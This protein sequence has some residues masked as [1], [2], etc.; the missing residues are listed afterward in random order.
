[1]SV[2]G[3]SQDPPRSTTPSSVT[4]SSSRTKSPATPAS[5]TPRITRQ[6]SEVTR[7]TRRTSAVSI[8]SESDSEPSESESE[9]TRTRSGSKNEESEK[10]APKKK[11]PLKRKEKEDDDTEK[12]E[13]NEKPKRMKRIVKKTELKTSPVDSDDDSSSPPKG[14]DFDLNEIRSQLKGFEK[15]VKVTTG[16]ADNI[17]E[18]KSP[19]VKSAEKKVDDKKPEKQVEKS[20]STE[21]IYEFKEPEPFEYERGLKLS[22][23]KGT[24]KRLVSRLFDDIDKPDKSPKH[25]GGKSPPKTEVKETEESKKRTFRRTPV[26]KSEDE[27]NKSPPKDELKICDDPFDKLVESPSF[28][29]G[30][31]S[32]EK[33]ET[34]TS[35]DITKSKVVKTLNLDEPLSLFSELPETVG[36]DSG[37]RL[38]ISD[39]DDIQGKPLFSHKEQLFT[40]A[41][42]SK[43]ENLDPI[44]RGFNSE[45]CDDNKKRSTKDGASDEDDPIGTAIHRALTHTLTDEDSINDYLLNDDQPTVIYRSKIKKEETVTTLP[46]KKEED[47]KEPLSIVM[48]ITKDKPKETKQI[49]PALQETDGSLL[50]TIIAQSELLKKKEV[51]EPQIKT[52]TKIADSILQKFSMIKKKEESKPIKVEIKTELKTEPS[53]E[54]KEIPVEPE[55]K[56]LPV[57]T[58]TETVDNKKRKKVVSREFI[59][60]SDTDSSDSEQ[61]LVIAR[62]DEDSQTNPS[63]KLDFKDT[64]SNTS[65]LQVNTDDS[66]ENESSKIFKFEEVKQEPAIEET[67]ESVKMET[68]EMKQEEDQDN[69]ISL[70]LCKETIPG[71]P[72]P[73]PEAPTTTEPRV[74]PKSARGLLLEMPFASAPGN[75]NSKGLLTN[76]VE[77]KQQQK[78]GLK[79]DSQ[80]LAIPLE[81][82][83]DANETTNPGMN[84]PPMTPE[85]TI[86][87]LSPR[88]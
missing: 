18:E 51:K 8:P 10:T 42:F 20:I 21:D 16:I 59:E 22:D 53:P 44:F 71:S 60:E 57:D 76:P 34:A 13:E 15:A 29:I 80:P 31:S 35:P 19:E 68:S 7:R 67:S 73:V 64:D 77:L 62:S 30:S 78:S 72:A 23:D 37:D 27:G 58:K 74:K 81:P 52:G 41:A 54:P 82:S 83:L 79:S 61:R 45:V 46:I 6:G 4:S 3:R 69:N 49:S 75:S 85:S 5:K 70:L 84:S 14:R 50:D 56:E 55:P 87:N 33:K 66:E 40:D 43:S 48:E 39:T 32:I 86:S 36:E 12:E 25:K 38:D 2:S 47:V 26:K 11:P 63:D 88:G 28:N 1:M 65:A 24:K 9:L 17:F